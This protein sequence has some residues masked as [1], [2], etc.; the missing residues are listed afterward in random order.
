MTD[1]SISLKLKI[2]GQP[3]YQMAESLK[4]YLP[5]ADW[6]LLQALLEI[7]QLENTPIYMVGGMVRDLLLDIPSVDFDL[8][9]EG[10]AI[11]FAEKIA[12]QYG[13]KIISHARFGTAVWM[14]ADDREK[15]AAK[16][17]IA[18]EALP[19]FLDFISARHERYARSGALPD[20]T[21]GD[22]KADAG[23]RDFSINT[24]ALRLDDKH[25]GELF[26]D[27]NGIEDL[28]KKSLRV[29]HDRSFEDD[30]TRILRIYRF[31]HR[32]KFNIDPD[33]ELLIKKSLPQ[34]AHISGERIRNEL[35]KLLAEKHSRECLQELEISG[36][37]KAIHAGFGIDQASLAALDHLKD[38]EITPE[39]GLETIPKS[40]L[41]LSIWLMQFDGEIRK[42][43][44]ESFNLEKPIREALGQLH[45]WQ[46]SLEKLEKMSVSGA[47]FWLDTLSPL[48]R[49]ALFVRGQ[50]MQG[51][52]RV[53]TYVDEWQHIHSQT[54]GRDLK[55]M[56]L[57]EGPKYAEILTFLRSAWLNDEISTAKEEKRLLTRLIGQ[58]E[59]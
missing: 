7:N 46:G 26:D 44:G 6:R 53:K 15:I 19:P 18:A 54:N 56:G 51:A 3:P 1:Q 30:P 5:L 23:R 21:F 38:F 36:V 9:L 27:W 12:G 11:A 13:G 52:G 16:L 47:T 34:L 48:A 29:L 32:L 20:V 55:E 14:I 2:K 22:I 57:E 25:F 37:L 42:A 59:D 49:L 33:S 17:G 58:I 39:W 50:G 10:N 40:W 24:L 45:D 41:A 43:L 35:D 4:A 8:V 28:E 31:K